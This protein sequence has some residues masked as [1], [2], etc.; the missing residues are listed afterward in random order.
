MTQLRHAFHVAHH[1]WRAAE[2]LSAIA[3]F[4]VLAP[5]ALRT[6]GAGKPVVFHGGAVGARRTNIRHRHAVLLAS[7]TRRTRVARGQLHGGRVGAWETLGRLDG[8]FE[9]GVETFGRGYRNRGAF[10]AVEAPGAQAAPLRRGRRQLAVEALCARLREAEVALAH[11]VAGHTREA[12]AAGLARIRSQRGIIP[13]R[14]RRRGA[15]GAVEARGTQMVRRC[16]ADAR[17]N[18][19]AGASGRVDAAEA[20]TD[21]P[22]GAGGAAGLRQHAVEGPWP[23]RHRLAMTPGRAHRAHR[24][25]E[26]LGK[27]AV[28]ARL[29]KPT[30][31]RRIA[32]LGAIHALEAW[33]RRR[34]VLQ[35][36]LGAR[37][38]RVAIV[39]FWTRHWAP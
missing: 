30:A 16:Q 9:S 37:N 36:R 17:A 8:A 29:A 34:E 10:G 19:A 24:A 11:H 3:Q 39:A 15:I 5:P 33:L 1:A 26:T 20:R 25:R 28:E 31:L 2:A 27:G 23:T 32:G 14:I 13:K 4:P 6:V 38:A 7:G 35:R 12:V 21:G 18:V 22:S